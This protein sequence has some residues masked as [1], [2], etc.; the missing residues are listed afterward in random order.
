MIRQ[1]SSTLHKKLRQL[2]TRIIFFGTKIKIKP[3]QAEIVPKQLYSLLLSLSNYIFW[4]RH[5]MFF[6]NQCLFR[7]QLMS[8]LTDNYFILPSKKLQK[9]P[10]LTRNIIVSDKAHFDPGGYLSKQNY[11]VW[12]T[13]NPDACID[14]KDCTFK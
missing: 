11:R 1:L 6:F 14:R 8:D 12:G 5:L 4:V 10:I 3:M 13:E 2:A 9:L 7:A